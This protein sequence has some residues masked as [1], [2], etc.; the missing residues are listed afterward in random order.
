MVE[1]LECASVGRHL[2]ARSGCQRFSQCCWLSPLA[3]SPTVCLVP[4]APARRPR[5]S[6]HRLP[7][8]PSRSA[9]PAVAEIGLVLHNL[10]NRVTLP[11]EC[12]ADRV[13]RFA[14]TRALVIE[15]RNS[16]GDSC[17]KNCAVSPS[18]VGNCQLRLLR[19]GVCTTSCLM[20]ILVSN[21]DGVYA[22]ESRRSLKWL[23]S[24]VRCGWSHRRRAIVNGTRDYV[25]PS[26]RLSP[27]EHQEPHGLSCQRN[28][29]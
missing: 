20:R 4:P 1:G 5:R 29:G 26:A 6:H 21:D 8:R 19:R 24:F 7:P 22:R 12:L 10:H 11:L 17:Y 25:L 28:T 2:G 18:V 23:Q 15:E 27:D 9:S 16:H 14:F 13:Q 3:K